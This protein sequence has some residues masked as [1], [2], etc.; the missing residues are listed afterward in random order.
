MADGDDDDDDDDDGILWDCWLV[1]FGWI[2]E[3]N[4][5]RC[6]GWW[7]L[8]YSGWSFRYWHPAVSSSLSMPFFRSLAPCSPTV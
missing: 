2:I 4:S 8:L 7:D 6:F 1:G 3:E 5:M